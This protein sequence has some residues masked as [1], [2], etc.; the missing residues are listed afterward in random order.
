MSLLRTPDRLR[1]AARLAPAL[2]AFAALPVLAQEEDAGERPLEAELVAQH[3]AL[4]PGAD[5]LLGLRL[6]HAPHWH[7][8]WINPGDSGLPTRL[9]WQVP[10][11]WRASDIEWPLPRRYAVGTLQNFGY[12]GEIVLPVALGVPADAKPGSRVRLAVTVKW[13]ACREAC[14]PGKDELTLELPVAADAGAADPRWGALF[15]EA[16]HAQPRP[17]PW[18]GSA[19]LVGERVRIRVSGP[20]LPPLQGLDAHAVQRKLIDNQPPSFRR[21]G[22]DLVIETNRSEYFT[23]APDRFDLVLTAP[24]AAGRRGWTLD[25]PLHAAATTGQAPH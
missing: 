13:L 5:A 9:A 8:Y 20:D 24:D 4:R 15:D 2:F 16:L 18:Q 11:G 6:R 12:E 22:T 3:A 25:L 14:I 17:A 21:D 7:S 23:S 10:Q 19:E 1:A